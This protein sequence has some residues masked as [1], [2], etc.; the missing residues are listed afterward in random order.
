MSGGSRGLDIANGG[1]PGGGFSAIVGELGSLCE[2]ICSCKGI[3][4]KI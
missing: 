1:F 4:T 2:E 3:L